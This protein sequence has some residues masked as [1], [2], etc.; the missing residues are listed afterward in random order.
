MPKQAEP[1]GGFPSWDDVRRAVSDP[2]R[3][4]AEAREVLGVYI[5]AYAKDGISKSGKD[6]D[7]KTWDSVDGVG[8][9]LAMYSVWKDRPLCVRVSLAVAWHRRRGVA[10]HIVAGPCP[11]RPTHPAPPR[12]TDPPP[13]GAPAVRCVPGRQG[14]QRDRAE[15]AAACRERGQVHVRRRPQV[16]R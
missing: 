16:L 12:H 9:S 3:T 15:S 11:P 6:P 13:P 4:D 8:W 5:R 2:K 10:L 7:G 14:R 1:D